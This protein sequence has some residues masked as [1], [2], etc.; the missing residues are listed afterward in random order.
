MVYMHKET[1]TPE[2]CTQNGGDCRN[3]SLSSY[4]RDCRNNKIIAAK[5]NEDDP[6]A[7]PA[8]RSNWEI[9]DVEISQDGGSPAK[10]LNSPGCRES[11][12][13]TV[14]LRA[15]RFGRSA[16]GDAEEGGRK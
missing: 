9:Y 1:V 11:L 16:E 3:C 4:G 2:Y 8:A 7:H 15:R 6:Q 13:I 12:Q 5:A 14:K 10:S